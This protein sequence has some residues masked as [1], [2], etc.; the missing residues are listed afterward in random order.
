MDK[1]KGE[2]DA[3]V[4]AEATYS[5]FNALFYTPGRRGVRIYGLPPQ[6]LVIATVTSMLF[7]IPLAFMVAMMPFWDTVGD[8]TPLKKLNSYVAPAIEGLTYEYR[9]MAVPRFPLKRFL[10]ASMSTIELIFLTNFIT[11]FARRVRKHA[12]LVWTCYDRTKVLQYFAISAFIFLGL[13]YV[14]F[15]D[16]QLLALLFS[17]SSRAAGRLIPCLVVPMPIV[18][19]IFGHMAMIVGLGTWRTVSRKLRHR[20]QYSPRA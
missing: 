7:G 20:A 16:W 5:A 18:A 17:A 3:N 1:S 12:L 4:A 13:W 11:L 8:F 2:T 10:I 14:L 15:F 6:Q 19:A 9:A